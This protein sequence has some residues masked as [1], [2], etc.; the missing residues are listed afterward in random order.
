MCMF[1]N[2]N[3]LSVLSVVIVIRVPLIIQKQLK[4]VDRLIEVSKFVHST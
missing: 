3:V 4:S 2:L 1:I